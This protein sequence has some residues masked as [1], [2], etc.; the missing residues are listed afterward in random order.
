MEI[1]LTPNNVFETFH[2]EIVGTWPT[3]NSGNKNL[4]IFQDAFSKNPKALPKPDQSIK[5]VAQHFVKEIICKNDTSVALVTDQGRTRNF[6]SELFTETCKLLNIKKLKTT[7][8][9]PQIN[10]QVERIHRTLMN[11]FGHK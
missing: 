10:G 5:T 2:L 11:Y 4:L 9:H 6:L 8:F 1:T 7:A 3:T